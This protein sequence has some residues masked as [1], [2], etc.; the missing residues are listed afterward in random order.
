[1]FYI[2]FETQ[3]LSDTVFQFRVITSN[4]TQRCKFELN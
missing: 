3:R 4:S 1:M 2:I